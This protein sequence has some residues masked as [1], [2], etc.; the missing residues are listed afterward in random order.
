MHGGLAW[1]RA[2]VPFRAAWQPSTLLRGFPSPHLEAEYQRSLVLKWQ[3]IEA[4]ALL[5]DGMT[6]ARYEVLGA[7]R[8]RRVLGKDFVPHLVFAVLLT[9]TS[10]TFAWTIFRAS[11]TWYCRYDSHHTAHAGA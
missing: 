10:F 8:G 4:A 1:M 9:L 2:L 6:Q 5:I 7:W 3:H 11:T